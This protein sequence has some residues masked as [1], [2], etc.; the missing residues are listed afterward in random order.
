MNLN[1]TRRYEMLTRV[2]KFGETH[3][4]LFPESSLGGRAFAVVAAAVAELTEHSRVRTSKRR[5]G[6]GARRTAREA[7]IPQLEAIVRT[8]RV[9]A[10]ES[11]GFDDPFYL[12]RRGSDQS[13]LT[14]GRSFVHD[15][16]AHTAEFVSH[17]LPETF[18]TD[19]EERVE[20][21]ERS[22]RGLEAGRDG[23]AAARAATEVAFASALAAVRKL[24]VLVVNQLR[25]DPVTMAVW[26]RD[27]RVDYRKR[28]RKAAAPSAVV[29]GETAAVPGA[30]A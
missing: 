1:E 23:E 5:M 21:F 24:D 7:L 9:I 30:A 17:N 28:T 27:R 19:L 18:V 26:E 13:L 25:A 2:S 3:R 15:A 12:P 4:E 20:E 8:A 10:V 11:P 14:A 6:Q 16:Q 29:S 22:V